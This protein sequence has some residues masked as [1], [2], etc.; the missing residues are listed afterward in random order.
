MG[1]SFSKIVKS[2]ANFFVWKIQILYILY[3]QFNFLE[4][5]ILSMLH[6]FSQFPLF[7]V[8][9][10]FFQEFFDQKF[11]NKESNLAFTYLSIMV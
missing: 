10:S 6:N 1:H 9:H 7:T 5:I 11:V 4:N 2:S 3:H 8:F